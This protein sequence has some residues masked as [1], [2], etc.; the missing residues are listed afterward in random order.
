MMKIVAIG[1]DHAGY[2][3]KQEISNWLL[4]QGHVVRDFGPENNESV[5]YPDFAHSVCEAVEQGGTE[6]GILICGT[7]IGMSMVANKHEGIR[8]GLCKDIA[9]AEMTRKHND[10]NVLCIGARNTQTELHTHIVDKFINTEFEGGR[11]QKRL[12]KF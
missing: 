1:S 12:D 2:E 9:T 7:G 5:D 6:I 8:A 11:H 4:E 10:A 3:V